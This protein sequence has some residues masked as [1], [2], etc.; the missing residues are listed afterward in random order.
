[1]S[2]TLGYTTTPTAGTFTQTSAAS[3]AAAIAATTP[4]GGSIAV[5]AVSA[6]FRASDS[7]T[8]T[9]YL[10]LWSGAGT[11][12]RDASVTISGGQQWYTATISEI[13]LLASQ[14]QFIG[15]QLGSIGYTTEYDN[16][17]TSYKGTSGSAPPQG[18]SFGT[19]GFGNIGAYITYNTAPSIS[20][21]S[22][23]N[24]GPGT[25]VTITGA[26]F[27]TVTSVAFNGTSAS[28]SITD[29]SHINATVP[30]GATTGLISVTNP[31]GT[32]NSASNYVVADG[33]VLRS[34]IWTQ[35]NV[36]V[37]RSSA[38]VNAQEIAVLRSSVWTPGA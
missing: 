6:H 20:S 1:M 37:E 28:F 38:Q 18:M 29:D 16:T 34:G 9:A 25:V 12:Q 27:S 8:Q 10:C 30:S 5:F 19:S 3:E 14:S 2:S 32:A 21:F 23:G 35:G 13:T 36:L 7:S 22:P 17:G 31:I 24:G 11:L 4:G 33:W 15:F 26:E